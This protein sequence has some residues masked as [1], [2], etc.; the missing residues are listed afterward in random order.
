VTGPRRLE[1]DIL[2]VG[3]GPVGLYGAYYAG[4]RGLSVVVMDSL[5]EPGGQVTAMYPEKPIFD[6]A[7]FPAV[8]GRDL[9]N[10]LLE[11][12]NQ[13]HPTYV[14]DQQA[15]GLRM[16]GQQ[17]VVSS[18]TGVQVRAGA[19]V[20]TAGIG[21]FSPR[22]LPAGGEWEGRGLAY[23]VPS[24]AEYAGEDVVVVGGGD[25]AFDWS[26]TLHPVARSVV[27]V[28]R[29]DRFRAHRA[30]VDAVLAR[31]IPLFTFCEVSALRGDGRLAEVEVTDKKTGA[32]RSLP[33]TRVVA[34]LGF[35][36]DLGP[37]T[38]WGLR[39]SGRHVEVGTRMA[40]SLARIYAAG[41]IT[42]YPGKVRLISVG[43]GEV[44]TAVN[45]A[46]VAIDPS[47]RLFPGH[48]SDH[49]ET[50]AAVPV[51]TPA[52]GSGDA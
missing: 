3:A 37:L 10:G 45:N 23:F 28:H 31:G 48:S 41:D 17:P 40:T 52:T 22:P 43:F 33:A 24:L 7:G 6:V 47:A 49:P 50:Y 2:I 5:P 19:V 44:A 30:T 11:Q 16:E 20:L 14:L 1:C 39:M 9:I 29:T 32:P 38:Q 26:L 25:S 18:A 42:E 36:T 13:F 34:A 27:Q 21:A 4:A 35:T 15:M 51:T 12:A 46:A 8:R